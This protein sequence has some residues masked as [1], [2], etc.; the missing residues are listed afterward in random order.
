MPEKNRVTLCVS[1]Q[2]GC[3]QA[4][5]F[6]YT[7]RMGLKRQLAVHE[8]VSQ[9]VM[10]N[11]W[12]RKNQQ[13]R[14][15]LA[16]P[17]GQTVN[18]LVFMGMGVEPLDNVEAVISAIEMITDPYGLALAPKRISVSTAG[19]VEGLRVLLKRMPRLSS[20]LSL[21]ATNDRDRSRLMP[22]NR[23]WPLKEL[24]NTFREHYQN[25][26][27]RNSLLVQYTVID[28]VNDSAAHADEMIELL[29]DLPVKINL[30]PLK[31]SMRV[32]LKALALKH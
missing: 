8:I 18:N 17:E 3:A 12:I 20:A 26:G 22:I 28:G 4:C 15:S 10:A 31:S 27:G 32:G 2:V 5:S 23:K 13:W 24:L 6:C 21:H 16:Y 19:H 7:G 11:E 30:I 25:C 14:Q 9:V 29:A 1:S